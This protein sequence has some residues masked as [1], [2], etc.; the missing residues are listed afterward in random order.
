MEIAELTHKM[1][2]VLSEFRDGELK[3]NRKNVVIVL[4]KCLDTLEQNGK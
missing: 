3:S 1:E 2:D 4:F